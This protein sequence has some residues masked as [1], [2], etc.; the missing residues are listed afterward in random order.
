MNLPHQAAPVR[1]Q[2]SESKFE[3]GR[4]TASNGVACQLCMAA[5]DQLGGT[6]KTLR[7]L[8]CQH[9]VC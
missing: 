2:V 1:R 7:R 3:A 9:T 8:A 6:A 4:V 5:C